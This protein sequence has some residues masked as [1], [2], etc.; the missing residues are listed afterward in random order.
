MNLDSRQYLDPAVFK[1][2][3]YLADFVMEEEGIMQALYSTLFWSTGG[4][5]G[6]ID[7]LRQGRW[8]GQ[9]LQLNRLST[10]REDG[11][12]DISQEVKRL[13]D[14]LGDDS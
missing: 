4:G 10:A 3:R 12:E 13:M 11:Y 6:D 2:G 14:N 7:E 5:G 9:R 1:S 8:A